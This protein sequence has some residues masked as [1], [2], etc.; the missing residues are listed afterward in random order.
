MKI[1][2]INLFLKLCDNI[3]V[4]FNKGL[5]DN[6]IAKYFDIFLHVFTFWMSFFKIVWSIIRYISTNLI[7]LNKHQD[8]K[9]FLSIIIHGHV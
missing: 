7:H 4:H 9:H 2:N 5:K 8:M 3:F 6:E 1:W